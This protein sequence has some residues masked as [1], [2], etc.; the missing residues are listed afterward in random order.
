[1]TS[2]R[3]PG[4]R[5]AR[6]NSWLPELYK[7][8]SKKSSRVASVTSVASIP[9]IAFFAPAMPV[10]HAEVVSVESRHDMTALSTL[11]TVYAFLPPLPAPPSVPVPT[12]Y[13]SAD[14]TV[15]A[16][17]TIA[18]VSTVSTASTIAATPTAKPI[19]STLPDAPAKPLPASRLTSADT[20]PTSGKSPRRLVFD[21]VGADEPDKRDKLAEPDDEFIDRRDLKDLID[22]ASSKQLFETVFSC[23]FKDITSMAI[24]RALNSV[25]IPTSKTYHFTRVIKEVAQDR[26]DLGLLPHVVKANVEMNMHDFK[27]FDIEAECMIT[28][29][30][31]EDA[32][33]IKAAAEIFEVRKILGPAL[34]EVIANSMN[35]LTKAP[36][37]LIAAMRKDV[38]EG[39]AVFRA[40]A[41]SDGTR[42]I[43]I[44]MFATK[45]GVK[46]GIGS[47]IMRVLRDL[48]RVSPMTAGHLAA[49]TVKTPNAK[50]F[51][52][53][54]LSE[55]GP[56]ARALLVSLACIDPIKTCV[57]AHLEM[58]YSAVFATYESV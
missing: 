48:T 29:V 27:R 34:P 5:F 23:A 47:A 15:S 24:L 9:P 20:P 18:A 21:A 11:P 28:Y 31:A 58:R 36:Y 43:T 55:K 40:H 30:V 42:L 38:V 45:E 7:I 32:A 1:M 17:S 35:T 49:F 53:R 44:E 39:A 19:N 2:A 3:T 14:S 56:M 8:I 52:A 12:R 46:P 57:E 25:K 13:A 16:A 22:M 6:K 50:R 10:P 4:G 54:K 33:K 37:F 51:Y 26:R 41:V